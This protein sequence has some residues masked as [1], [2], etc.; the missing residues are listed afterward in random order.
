MVLFILQSLFLQVLSGIDG[1]LTPFAFDKILLLF[2]MWF[3]GP[4]ALMTLLNST[5]ETSLATFSQLLDL[6]EEE[7]SKLEYRFTTMPNKGVIISGAV[8]LIFYAVSVIGSYESLSKDF[9]FSSSFLPISIFTG[10]IS[11]SVGSAIYYHSVRQLI[12]VTRTVGIA[13]RFNL[14]QLDPIYTL[15]RLT[16]RTGIAWTRVRQVG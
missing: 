14:N 6:E 7:I 3:W 10:M 11:F 1:W 5:S 12:L 16:A 4:L 2:P 15:S 8:W 13:S 9:R